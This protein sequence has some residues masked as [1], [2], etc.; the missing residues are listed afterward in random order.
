MSMAAIA[1]LVLAATLELAGTSF[2]AFWPVKQQLSLFRTW[3]GWRDVYSVSGSN[4]DVWFVS[5]LH[6]L[7][8]SL[9]LSVL[10][11]SG[12]RRCSPPST[13][14]AAISIIAVACQ[15]C[16]AAL[17]LACLGQKAQT[18]QPCCHLQAGLLAKCV[19]VA[20]LG[21]DNLMP[22]INPHKKEC[23][24]GLVFMFAS[25]LISAIGLMAQVYAAQ[26]VL[27]GRLSSF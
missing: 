7:L 24:V 27:T 8:I 22:V 4:L 16:A 14:R 23:G 17:T 11:C 1:I 3:H 13:A 19:L 21:G 5:V 18:E 25:V 10:G 6:T 9:V 20:L 12:Q 2:C 15:V 26:R